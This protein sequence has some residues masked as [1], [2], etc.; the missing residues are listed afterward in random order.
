MSKPS[1]LSP[2]VSPPS[3]VS[4]RKLDFSRLQALTEPRL[5][6]YI[7]HQ[8]TV[9]QVAG[10][11]LNQVSEVFYGGAAGGGKSDW[12][13]MGALQYVDV[14]GYAALILRRTYRDL[15]LPGALMSR[16]HEWLGPSDARWREDEKTWVFPTGAT[17]TFGYLETERDKYRY[18]SSAF[19]YIGFDE[20]TQFTESQYRYMFSRRRRLEGANA[21]LRTRAASN[22]GDLGHDWVK[23]RFITEGREYGRV[24]IPAKLDDNPYLDRGEYVKSLSELDPVTRQQLLD[25]DWTARAAGNL[26]RRE[27]FE[28]VDSYPAGL[29]LVRYWDLAS[30]EATRGRDPDWTAGALMGRSQEG[31]YYLLDMRRMRGQPLAVEGLVRQMAMTDGREVGIYMEQEPGSS[32]V[33]TI[34]HYTR[35]VLSG[36]AFRGERSTGSKLSRANPVSSQAEAGNIKLLRGAWIGEFLDEVEAFPNGS[37]DDQVDAMSG[38]F[39]QVVG[40]RWVVA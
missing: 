19:Q 34:D 13:L 2:T 25:G 17:L 15:A 16:A 29:G 20:L 22:P 18:Q 7:P 37:H 6:S 5:T 30:T 31:Q 27:W 36:W 3:S 38:A 10:L 14:P 1:P 40:P 33:N 9:K 8:P 35:E 12:L 23:Q 11:L 24:F 26:F 21:P 32:G 28:V 4:S 39:E